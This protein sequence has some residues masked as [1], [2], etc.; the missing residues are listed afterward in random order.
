MPFFGLTHGDGE[1]A[2]EMAEKTAA[3]PDEEKSWP[4]SFSK[5]RD[6]D[7]DDAG[8]KDKFPLFPGKAAARE[9]TV[10]EGAILLPPEALPS[11]GWPPS[12]ASTGRGLLT[13][14]STIYSSFYCECQAAGG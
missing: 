6:L 3:L 1:W 7:A 8:L 14:K 2:E 4:N 5:I 9:I 10:R 13:L 11:M 12:V